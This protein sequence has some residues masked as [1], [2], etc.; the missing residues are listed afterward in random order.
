VIS[1]RDVAADQ[2]TF[3]TLG[4]SIIDVNR[5]CNEA[6]VAA[7]REK[8]GDIFYIIVF[9]L[10]EPLYK[11]H[12]HLKPS[13]WDQPNLPLDLEIGLAAQGYWRTCGAGPSTARF[14]LRS[15]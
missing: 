13:D 1:D 2:Q 12:P 7:Y 10:L 3:Q 8:I 6:E 14:A 11:Q 15:G 9:K 5:R 4:D